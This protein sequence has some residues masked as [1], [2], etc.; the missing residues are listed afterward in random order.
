[1]S[2]NFESLILE[3]V[4]ASRLPSK[5]K[6]ELRKELF[7][8]F[9]DEQKELQL[10]GY[11]EEK[12]FVKIKESFGN[13]QIVSKELHMIH[14]SLSLRKLLNWFVII[15]PLLWLL[16]I[17]S[18]I[19]LDQSMFTGCS[20]NRID[21]WG[22]VPLVFIGSLVVTLF[23]LV[24]YPFSWV[25]ISFYVITIFTLT[26]I[27]P[28]LKNYFKDKNIKNVFLFF[29]YSVGSIFQWLSLFFS[30][31]SI[32]YQNP[33]VDA[34]AQGGFPIKVFDYPMVSMGENMDVKMFHGI[35]YFYLNYIIWMS[36]ATILYYV[37][38]EKIKKNQKVLS[39]LLVVAITLSL[40]G[41]SYI[42]MKF[43]D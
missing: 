12:I 39:M 42:L 27:L 30:W 29:I 1:M 24:I 41:C 19:F 13:T 22:F 36:L 37:L 17:V 40:Y 34:V 9:F 38:P 16:I 15:F 2:D 4:E 8:H 18:E 35:P 3:T 10:Q 6:E 26:K 32:E 28:K 11:S 5:K 20:V 7:A 25:L 33:R 31:R 21:C 23:S 43:D 14:T